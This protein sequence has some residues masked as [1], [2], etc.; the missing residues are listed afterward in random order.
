MKITIEGD[1]KETAVLALSVQERQ[2]YE[3]HMD[4][5][6]SLQTASEFLEKVKNLSS[7]KV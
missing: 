2:K 4:N 5:C 7:V 3:M 6:I 1:A